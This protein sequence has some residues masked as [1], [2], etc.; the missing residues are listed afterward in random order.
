MRKGRKQAAG[1]AGEEPGG[2]EPGADRGGSPEPGSPTRARRKGAR[3]G[4][5]RPPGLRYSP[6]ERRRLM[7]A[8][9]SGLLGP[10]FLGR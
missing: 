6:E 5:G 7:E 9:I 4:H 8:P 10:A 1:K 2:G 3:R